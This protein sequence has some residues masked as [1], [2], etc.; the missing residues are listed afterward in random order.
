MFPQCLLRTNPTSIS[1]DLF[2]N[3]VRSAIGCP[4]WVDGERAIPIWAPFMNVGR[5]RS[6]DVGDELWEDDRQGWPLQRQRTRSGRARKTRGQSWR[7]SK[8]GL[9]PAIGPGESSRR[10]NERVLERKGSCPR[11]SMS[12]STL[13]AARVRQ[14]SATVG[15]YQLGQR[16]SPAVRGND[17]ASIPGA[18]LREKTRWNAP[19]ENQG[20]RNCV[21][22]L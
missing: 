6:S 14:A 12:T 13:C 22:F 16:G 20:T 21:R 9:W 15:L 7:T 5:A 18:D 4:R 19:R 1:E 8:V 3:D 10:Q 2:W 17:S 11:P